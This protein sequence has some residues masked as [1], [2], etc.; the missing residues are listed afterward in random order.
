M[1]GL[2]KHIGLSAQKKIYS[3]GIFV[4]C[5]TGAAAQSSAIT[6]DS[7]NK[8]NVLAFYHSIAPEKVIHPFQRIDYTRP[9]DQLMSWPNYPLTPTE[10][11]RRHRVME[12]DSKVGNVI[13]KDIIT[14]LLKK[15]TKV[16]VIPKF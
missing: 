14:G 4:L 15:K 8:K 1:P 5:F 3:A 6:T 10:I 13:A 9:N 2:V 11:E 7:S 16:A 12:R